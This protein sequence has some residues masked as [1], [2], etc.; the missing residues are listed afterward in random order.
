MVICIDTGRQTTVA[1]HGHLMNKF[2]RNQPIS[3]YT[4]FGQTPVKLPDDLFQDSDIREVSFADTFTLQ[5][6][7]V[8]KS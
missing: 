7:D 5:N 4:G 6:Y 8:S 3:G 2:R 1:G